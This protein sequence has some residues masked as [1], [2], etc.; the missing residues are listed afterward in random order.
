MKLW[1]K[2]AA[3][4]WNEALPIGN[5]HLGGM[6]YGSATK[7]CIQLNDETIWYRGKSDR[8]NPDSLLHLKKIREYLLD[9]EIH[10]E[11]IDI[12][13]C[14]LSLYER[15]LDLDTAISNV[16]FEPN[17]CNLQIKREYFTSF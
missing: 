10:I 4:N 9:G 2:K 17:S 3:S 7:E 1:Y 5:G 6:I 13:S 15:E 11:H 8:N 16:V 14:A 12:Q